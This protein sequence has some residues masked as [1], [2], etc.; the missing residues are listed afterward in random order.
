MKTLVLNAKQ[1]SELTQIHREL[2]YA[3]QRCYQDKNLNQLIWEIV[4]VSGI[5]TYKNQTHNTESVFESLGRFSGKTFNATKEKAQ[6]YVQNGIASEF[7]TDYK[8]VQNTVSSSS[9][10]LKKAGQ[11]SQLYAKSFKTH[12]LDRPKNEKLGLISMGLMSILSFYATADEDNLINTMP[13]PD[14]LLSI[15]KG[16]SA[17]G[18]TLVMGV[19]VDFL[20]HSGI[21]VLKKIQTQLPKNSHQFWRHTYQSISTH[22]QRP[23]GALWAEISLHLI[24]DSA[25]HTAS[26]L[27]YQG[28]PFAFPEETT[29]SLALINDTTAQIFSPKD[30]QA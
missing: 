19:L 9:Q 5:E 11:T 28:S 30:S 24:Q 3:L 8:S 18:S 27:P 26:T 13:D 4:K 14:L 25:L 7:K 16:S 20:M 12:F 6:K 29:E 21:E 22:S 17:M 15:S 23:I 2:F 10:K 1:A